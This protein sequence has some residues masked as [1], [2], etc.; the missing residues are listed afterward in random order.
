MKIIKFMTPVALFAAVALASTGVCRAQDAATAARA[1]DFKQLYEEQKRR[2]DD[3]ERRLRVLEEHSKQDLEVAKKEEPEETLKKKEVPEGKEAPE[4]PL[5]KKD[6]PEA[7]LQFLQDTKISGFVSASYF[8]NFN[9]PADGLNTGRG[10]DINHDEF[11]A[12]KFDLV[13]EK[14]VDYD[15]SAWQAGYKAELIFGQDAAFTQAGG[16]SLGNQGDLF[17]GYAEFNVPIGNGLKVYFGKYQ[18]VIGYEYSETELNANWSGGN[19]WA[20][21]EPFTHTG[22]LL[23]YKWSKLFETQI[24]VNNGW[25]IVKD[26]NRSKSFMGIINFTPNDDNFASLTAFGGPEQAGNNSNWRKGVDF[27]ATHKFTPKFSTAAQIDYGQEDGAKVVGSTVDADGNLVPV[28]S[29][30]AQWWAAGLWLTYDFSETLSTTLRGDYVNDINGARTSQAPVSAPFPINTGQELY[31]LTLTVNVKPF[32]GLRIAPE[33]R[34]DHSTL[35]TAFG[36]HEDQVTVGLG[37]AYFF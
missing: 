30:G 35:D 4:E 28:T 5:K 29:G 36:G 15:A 17:L 24:L 33:I 9:R 27:V 32:K 11:M 12:N 18:T 16:L 1:T 6:L 22:L 14:A 25:D 26:N 7:T 2:N 37:A 3:L 31:S 20:I 13:L 23:G 34:W 19:Q 10:F 21:L 8:Y